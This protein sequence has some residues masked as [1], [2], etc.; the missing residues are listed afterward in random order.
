[1]TRV[2]IRS[3]R[4]PPTPTFGDLKRGA[5]FLLESGVAGIKVVQ[6]RDGTNALLL[7]EEGG[8]V[9]SEVDDYERVVPLN[10]VIREE[11]S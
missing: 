3:E 9:T 7:G 2:E 10:L 11:A 8:W 5:G 4:P 1:M 6:N